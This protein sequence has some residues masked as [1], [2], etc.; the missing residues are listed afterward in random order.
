MLYL[1]RAQHRMKPRR[2]LL[3]VDLLPT[4]SETQEDSSQVRCLGHPS[5][6]LEDY[7]DSIKELAQPAL[8]PACGPL[9]VQRPQRSRLSS[10][11][12]GKCSSPATL[13]CGAAGTCKPCV[14]V[15]L[16]NVTLRFAA[17]RDCASRDPLDWLFAQTQYGDSSL[18]GNISAALCLL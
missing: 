12:L 4:I 5:Q 8:L 2:L 6:S 16:D 14:P 3:S 10:V 7:F 15:S 11:P 9:R 1:E 13:P 17:G 18:T